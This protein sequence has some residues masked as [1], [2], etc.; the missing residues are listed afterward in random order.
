MGALSTA[1]TVLLAVV[2]VAFA[3]TLVLPDRQT[4]AV[5]KAIFDGFRGSLATSMT[6]RA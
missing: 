2:G 1:E 3:T 5:V 6:G 4:P